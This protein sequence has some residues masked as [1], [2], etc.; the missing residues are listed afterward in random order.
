MRLGFIG[1]GRMGEPIARRLLHASH[2]L[3]VWNRSP[4]PGRRLQAEGA[5]Y[6]ESPQA[7]LTHA[8]ITF[9]SLLNEAALDAVLARSGDEIGVPVAGRVVVNLGTTSADYSA[10][11][12]QAIEARAGRYV[13]LPVS[14]SRVPAEQGTLVA[15]LAGPSS[16]V[17]AVRALAGAFSRQVHDCGEVPGAMRMKLAV[18]HYL[19]A[20]VAAL[21]ETFRT[22]RAL[23]IDPHALAAVLDAGPMASE[24]SRA[25]AAKIAHG[26]FEAQAAIADVA[27]IATL[28]RAQAEEAGTPAPLI[29]L[30]QAVFARAL[31]AGFGPH[32]MAAI[33]APAAPSFPRCSITE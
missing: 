3:T 21:A 11:L 9:V 16:V 10:R 12:A 31:D 19:I 26:D 14:G 8:E 32:D 2:A 22:A 7:V 24:V 18:N 28:V 25:K 30:A 33:A 29:A 4:E 17:P 20:M 15:M 27:T 5:S 23:G 13:E 1:L 6:A